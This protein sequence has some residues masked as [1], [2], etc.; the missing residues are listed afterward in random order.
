MIEWQI[1][2]DDTGDSDPQLVLIVF[3]L[4]DLNVFIFINVRVTDSSQLVLI[5]F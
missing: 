5:V 3:W 2:A 4:E 1:D